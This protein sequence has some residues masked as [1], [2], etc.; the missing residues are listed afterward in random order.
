MQELLTF[1]ALSTGLELTVHQD[2]EL[3]KYIEGDENKLRQIIVN[4]VGNAIKF[5][6]VGHIDLHLLVLSHQTQSREIMLQLEV[7]DPGVG[8]DKDDLETIFE[9]F[10]QTENTFE[11]REG[12]GLGLSISRQFARLMGGDIP[13]LSKQEL[14]NAKSIIDNN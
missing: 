13:F 14:K 10:K 12:T 9:A 1:K 4:L 6:H 3:P 5:T 8:I 2:A 11:S 7:K